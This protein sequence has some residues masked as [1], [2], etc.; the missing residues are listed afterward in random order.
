MA[1]R[2]IID[3]YQ[4]SA[5]KRVHSMHAVS[6][7]QHD[8][9]KELACAVIRLAAED[10]TGRQWSERLQKFKPKRIK[11]R[12][13]RTAMEFINGFTPGPGRMNCFEFVCQLANVEPEVVRRGV[14]Q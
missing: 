12:E 10:A 1:R 14:Q 4:F 8:G 9:I 5:A 6:G 3:V 2:R 11:P 13:R 7:Y